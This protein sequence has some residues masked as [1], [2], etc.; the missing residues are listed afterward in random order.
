MGRTGTY[1][2]IDAML[3]RVKTEGTIDV[4]GYLSYMRGQRNKMVQ[5][6]VGCIANT[7]HCNFPKKIR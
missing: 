4:P 6:E 1:I 2:A 3:D 5:T 7:E